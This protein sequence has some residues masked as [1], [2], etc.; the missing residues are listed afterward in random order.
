MVPPTLSA[1]AAATFVA[2]LPRLTVAQWETAVARATADAAMRAGARAVLDAIIADRGYARVEQDLASMLASALAD[3]ALRPA[4][5]PAALRSASITT[6]RVAALAVLFR[7]S[8]SAADFATL[9]APFA[10]VL[11]LHPCPDVAGG[12]HGPGAP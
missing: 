3:G 9:C 1:A 11:A 10:D 5:V 8:L 6:G 2:A 7:P 12:E 4:R